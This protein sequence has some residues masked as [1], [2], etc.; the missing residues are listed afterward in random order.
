MFWCDTTKII[1]QSIL[2]FYQNFLH[3]KHDVKNCLLF[4]SLLGNIVLAGRP[5]IYDII[6][7]TTSITAWLGKNNITVSWFV[8]GVLAGL[9]SKIKLFLP[10]VVEYSNKIMRQILTCWT[11]RMI[12][13]PDQ[14]T[15][16][17]EKANIL[18]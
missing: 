18:V 3:Y 15:R 2:H 16:M 6:F 8:K 9:A 17:K 7:F 4:S 14:A 10:N 11:N 5:K 13:Y 12:D 1:I